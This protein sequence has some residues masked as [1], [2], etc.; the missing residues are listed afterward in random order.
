MNKPVRIALIFYPLWS[1]YAFSLFLAAVNFF[2]STFFGISL[3]T[4]LS[5][6]LILTMIWLA[7][8]V[9]LWF[10]LLLND[11]LDQNFCVKLP[12]YWLLV[13]MCMMSSSTGRSFDAAFM[14]AAG[15]HPENSGFQSPPSHTGN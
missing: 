8:M 6:G 14:R 5:D 9:G 4:L 2:I 12:L 3:C 7:L 1:V 10:W 13:F 15:Y 11:S